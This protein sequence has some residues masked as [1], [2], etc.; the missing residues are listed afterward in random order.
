MREQRN[1]VFVLEV[2]IV[3][4]R[5]VALEAA[6]K[7]DAFKDVLAAQHHNYLDNSAICPLPTLFRRHIKRAR[8]RKS[9]ILLL[10]FGFG[11][12]LSDPGGLLR[13]RRLHRGR[14]LH[15]TSKEA[16]APSGLSSG[17]LGLLGF[18]LIFDAGPETG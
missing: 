16:A 11:L 13:G 7:I 15:D 14:S 8:F 6:G 2:E 9:R 10:D 17:G 1:T 5:I 18:D 12:G 4:D 3:V